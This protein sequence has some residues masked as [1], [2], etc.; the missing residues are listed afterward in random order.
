MST[1]ATKF[2]TDYKLTTKMSLEEL[3]Q[4]TSKILDLLTDDKEKRCQVCNYLIKSITLAKSK[5][6]AKKMN[7]YQVSD[8]I[9]SRKTIKE[10]AQC[11]MKD[12]LSKRDIKVISKTL[13]KTDSDFVVEAIIFEKLKDSEKLEST[14]LSMF[15]KKDELLLES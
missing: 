7:I 5:A 2:V 3:S 13:V 9:C 12:K 15:L 1:I 8:S 6:E 10:T 11:I 14:Y 4:Y